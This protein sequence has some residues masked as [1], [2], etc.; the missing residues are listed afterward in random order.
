MLYL[1]TNGINNRGRNQ[2]GQGLVEFALVIPIMLLL[3]WGIIEFGRM[4]LIYTEVSNAAREAVRYGITLGV[5]DEP[6]YLDC[7]G[8]T[9]AGKKSTA[10]TPLGENNF[11]IY[12][13]HGDGAAY[14]YCEDQP[15]YILAGDR[16]VISVSYDVRPLI[17]FQNA[18]PFRIEM[19][20]ARTIVDQGL[21]MSG[22][23]ADGFFDMKKAS[24]DAPNP[25]GFPDNFNFEFEPTCNGSGRFTWN[26]VANASGYH[27]YHNTLGQING[28]IIGTQFPEDGSYYSPLENGG[29]YVRAFDAQ[30]YEGGLSETILVSHTLCVYVPPP[31]DLQFIDTD[32]DCVGYFEWSPVQDI[33]GYYLYHE[34][35]NYE[36]VGNVSRFPTSDI[37]LFN[38]GTYTLTAYASVGNESDSSNSAVVA[39]CVPPVPPKEPVIKF[40][41]DKVWPSCQG[42]LSWTA[43][44]AAEGYKIYKG[45]PLTLIDQ[46]KSG[47]AERYPVNSSINFTDGEVYVV[48]AYNYGGSS[49]DSNQV[50]IAQCG[51]N[52]PVSMK[53]YLQTRWPDE[54]YCRN[55]DS[56]SPLVMGERNPFCHDVYDYDNGDG[57][58]RGRKLLDGGIEPT[59]NNG[60]GESD[61]H[62]FLAWQSSQLQNNLVLSNPKLKI[63]YLTGELNSIG[64]IYLCTYSDAN[65]YTNCSS[66]NVT[67][68]KSINWTPVTVYW[69]GRTVRKGDRLAVYITVAKGKAPVW[70]IYDKLEFYVGDAYDSWLEFTGQWSVP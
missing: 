4:F 35:E 13:D 44:P 23:E 1:R 50:V 19:A 70:F 9:N 67:W 58:P 42:Y 52:N 32:A 17:L 61:P 39:D 29:Y 68:S 38:F 65:G 62:H 37:Q 55:H 64:N 16:L 59:G 7:E 10:L 40:V 20:A 18:G 53:L 48:R 60:Q 26:S 47:L 6:R 30:G 24:A 5:F 34:G 63:W 8:I 69:G 46:V 51:N 11:E 31:T 25:I 22:F 15:A 41:L 45:S 28:D 2:A 33:N 36:D 54:I 66:S 3:V 43:I 57:Y 27:I 12:Y 14:A 21:V 49:G 56:W